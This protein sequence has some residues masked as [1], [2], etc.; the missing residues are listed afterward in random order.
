MSCELTKCDIRCALPRSAIRSG[1]SKFSTSTATNA[2]AFFAARS[3]SRIHGNGIVSRYSAPSKA[4][5]SGY[6]GAFAS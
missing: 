6:G 2:G 5:M 4:T 3:V 1:P